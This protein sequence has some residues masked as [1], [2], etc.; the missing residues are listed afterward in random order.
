MAKASPSPTG[1]AI[2]LREVRTDNQYVSCF[3]WAQLIIAAEPVTIPNWASWSSTVVVCYLLVAVVHLVGHASAEVCAFIL[4]VL[5]VL[6]DAWSPSTAR[7]AF[8]ADVL[9]SIPKDPRTVLHHLKLEPVAREFICCAKCFKLY[10]LHTHPDATLRCTD[11]PSPEAEECG[12]PIYRSVN[13]RGR[14]HMYPTRM[15]YHQD[16]HAWVARLLNRPGVEKHLIQ[17]VLGRGA[18]PDSEVDDIWRGT[19]LRNF[20]GRDGQPF[21][22]P[23]ASTIKLAFAL[24][25]DGF[26]PFGT[27]SNKSV[28]FHGIFLVCLNL[29][30]HMRYLEDNVYLAGVGP[31]PK[32]PTGVQHNHLLSPVVD[33]LLE[34]WNPGVHISST[35][36]HP[37]G[38]HLRSA[39]IPLVVDMIAAKQTLALAGVTAHFFCTYCDLQYR[40]I[41]NIDDSTW[42]MRTNKTWR[43]SANR[44]KD[45]PTDALQQLAFAETGIR[46]SELLRLPYF[47]PPQ[48]ADPETMHLF[49]L[50]VFLTQIRE[51]MQMR[52]AKSALDAE[53]DIAALKVARRNAPVTADDLEKALWAGRHD[54]VASL[55]KYFQHRPRKLLLA[56][57]ARLQIPEPTEKM[58]SSAKHDVLF[59]RLI[60]YVSVRDYLSEC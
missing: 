10:P 35:V 23:E 41:N 17:P 6:L 45:A 37:H 40:D 29:P 55:Y 38:V 51:V 13:V 27:S 60:E 25:V 56:V 14:T 21:F 4:Q 43:Q 39:L 33:D 46:W 22:R 36:L 24:C 7:S 26:A 32:G 18:A 44:W 34:S 50:R 3:V 30:L 12:A 16:F 48:F 15:F 47:D 31:G 28:S 58:R 2:A 59:E 52:A 5:P 42:K 1:A 19:L 11:R 57:C 54:G 9:G 49:D 8:G 53:T 20:K